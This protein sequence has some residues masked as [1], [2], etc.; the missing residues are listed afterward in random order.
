MSNEPTQLDLLKTNTELTD[1][2]RGIVHHSDLPEGELARRM[3]EDYVDNIHSTRLDR[4][5]AEKAYREIQEE[6]RV[7][8]PETSIGAAYKDVP[9]I[10]GKPVNMSD[11]EY[12]RRRTAEREEETGKGKGGKY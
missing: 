3:E 8:E 4:P 2:Q 9:R 7:K 6:L 1:L 5:A 11:E 10:M 12:W